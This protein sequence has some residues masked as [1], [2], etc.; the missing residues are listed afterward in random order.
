MRV[1]APDYQGGVEDGG[2]FEE[3]GGR[4]GSDKLL[5]ALDAGIRSRILQSQKYRGAKTCIF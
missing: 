4:G 1:A 3:G 2:Y 5:Y